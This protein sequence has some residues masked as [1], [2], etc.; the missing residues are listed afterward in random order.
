MLTHNLATRPFYNARAV[1]ALLLAVTVIVVAVGAFDAWEYWQLRGTRADLQ[2]RIEDAQRRTEDLR[3]RAATIRASINTAELERTLAT[4]EE[5]NALIGRRVFSWTELLNHVDNTIPDT[6][7]ITAIRPR[8]DRTEG[9]IVAIVVVARN[10]EGINGFIEQ[11]EAAGAF[12]G[13]LSRD[14]FIKEDGTIQAALEGRYV[15]GAGRTPLRARTV[16]R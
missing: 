4:V 1:H 10:V 16:S 2:A 3:S 15:P 11:L 6:V 12:S 9:L 7:R 13:L 14:E 5:V 8:V